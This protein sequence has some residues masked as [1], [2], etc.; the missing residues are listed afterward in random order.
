MMKNIQLMLFVLFL[1][2]S[3]SAR[4]QFAGAQQNKAT[5]P[6]HL[7][8]ARWLVAHLDLHNTGYEHG[9][10][11]VKFTSP[12]ISRTDCS[13]FADALLTH[14]YGYDA[15]QFR[16][17]FGS[18]R[19]T[20]RRYHDA[21]EQQRG[22]TRIKH[23]R[24]VLPGDFL[25][26]K[27]LT[28]NDNTGHVMLAADRPAK[29]LPMAPLVPGTEQWKVVVIDSSQSGHGPTDT[30]HKKGADGKDHDGLGEGVLRVYTNSRGSI[31]GFAWST[32]AASKYKDPNDEDLVIGRLQIESEK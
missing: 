2:I 17:W 24:D 1:A 16:Q 28:R 12:C 14:C 5:E 32:L 22:F 13:G 29:I 15:D 18:G 27:Y 3:Q 9:A 25:A 19:P 26:V 11:T 6:K 20:A 23:V 31:V 7:A 21:I 30:R 4:G 8:T 10:G